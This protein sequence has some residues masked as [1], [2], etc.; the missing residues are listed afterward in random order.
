[1]RGSSD[2]HLNVVDPHGRDL[3]GDP[4]RV[5][6]DAHADP[7]AVDLFVLPVTVVSIISYSPFAANGVEGSVLR[8]TKE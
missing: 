6:G 5:S 4:R 2:R 1:V 8:A 7:I 3:A